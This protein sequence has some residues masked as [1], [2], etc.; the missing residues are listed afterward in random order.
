MS[1]MKE[2]YFDITTS[3]DDGTSEDV[4]IRRLIEWFDMEYKVAKDIFTSVKARHMDEVTSN[5]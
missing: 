1:K 3:I 5:D 2:L 4:I